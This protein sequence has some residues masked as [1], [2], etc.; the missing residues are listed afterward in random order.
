MTVFQTPTIL[1]PTRKIVPGHRGVT[2][3]VPGFGKYESTLE[4]DLMEI[5]RFDPEVEQF[6]AQPLAIDYIDGEGTLRKYTPD[7]FIKFVES[8]AQPPILFEVKHRE[9]FRKEWRTLMP[10][11]RAAKAYCLPRGWKF[12]VFTERE[13]RT[14]YLSNVKFL[15]PFVER[16]PEKTVADHVLMLLNDLDQADPELLLCALCSDGANRAN[17]IPVIWHLVAIGAIDCDLTQ[18]LT[19]RSLLQTQGAN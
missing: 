17:F 18:P 4:R 12:E 5:L 19:M 8:S 2:G 11:F 13:I 6:V 14:T 9:D 3:T 7:G 10:K 15:W 16:V 1:K